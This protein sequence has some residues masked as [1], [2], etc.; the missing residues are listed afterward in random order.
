MQFKVFTMIGSCSSQSINRKTFEQFKDTAL[1]D[2][3]VFSIEQLPHFNRDWENTPPDIVAEFKKRISAADGVLVVTP[4]YNRSI[5]GVLKNALD[6]A[7]RPYGKNV[8]DNKPGAVMGVS[9][10]GIGTFGA[11]QHLRN[12]MS[13]LNIHVMSQPEVYFNFTANA[14]EHG[15]I[16]QSSLDFFNG[17]MLAFAEWIKVFKK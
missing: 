7:S 15:K 4:E 6:T 10:G 11:Q 17:F 1:L 12:I 16:N 9:T 2:F 14:D 5:P 3:D 13:Y 8:W